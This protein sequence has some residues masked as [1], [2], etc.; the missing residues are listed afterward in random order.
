MSFT[1]NGVLYSDEAAWSLSEAFKAL[2]D[3]EARCLREFHDMVHDAQ[4]LAARMQGKSE[5]READVGLTMD[6]LKLL[7]SWTDS[8]RRLR[9]DMARFVAEE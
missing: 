3:E 6:V 1:F 5:A 2:P 8:H 9:L 4:C 7:V